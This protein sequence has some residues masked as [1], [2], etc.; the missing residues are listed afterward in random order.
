[1][2]RPGSDILGELRY[3]AFGRVIPAVL[4]LGLLWA[5]LRRFLDGIGRLGP[6]QTPYSI[7]T[8][9]VSS[10]L[11]VLFIAI[12][13]AI[14]ITRPRPKARDGRIVAR[15]AAFVATTMLLFAGSPFGGGPVLVTPPA[16]HAIAALALAGAYALEVYALLYLRLS[17]SIIPEARRLVRGGPYRMVRHP[18][19]SA[20]IVGAMGVV[21]ADSSGPHLWSMGIL[22]PF[23]ALQLLRSVYEERLL[24]ATFTE[25]AEY[26]AHTARLI[27]F[28]L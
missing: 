23:I 7:I 21:F 6:S 17:F 14:Y 26:A 11:Y 18:L 19:Y 12:P 15:I 22:I 27:P 10:G 16:V 13:V 20:E 2:L 4:Y 24:R 1:M 8:G 9:P 25:Y 3:L 5:I 28:V